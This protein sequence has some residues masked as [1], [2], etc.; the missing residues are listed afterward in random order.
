MKVINDKLLDADLCLKFDRFLHQ[1]EDDE[2]PF[3]ENPRKLEKMEHILS[4]QRSNYIFSKWK[5]R[6]GVR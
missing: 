3:N 2:C 6:L 5:K 4:R 1:L